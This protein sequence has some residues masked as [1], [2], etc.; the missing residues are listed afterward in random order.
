MIVLVYQFPLICHVLC[1]NILIIM[2]N[3]AKKKR[4]V[5]FAKI[6]QCHSSQASEMVQFCTHV[7]GVE[8][9]FNMLVSKDG[10]VIQCG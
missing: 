3:T 10:E 2:K 5:E 1:P 4:E 8:Q 7:L 6:S 9:S